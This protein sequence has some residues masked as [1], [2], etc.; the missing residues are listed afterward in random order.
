MEPPSPSDSYAP[1][2]RIDWELKFYSADAGFQNFVTG[3]ETNSAYIQFSPFSLWK[4]NKWLFWGKLKKQTFW[5]SIYTYFK[6]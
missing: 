6:F 5:I 3:K 1:F 2:G 4:S